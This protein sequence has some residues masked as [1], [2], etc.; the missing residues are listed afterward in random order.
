MLTDFANE[1]IHLVPGIHI[2]YSKNE[3][4]LQKFKKKNDYF[5]S[6][7]SLLLYKKRIVGTKWIDSFA[8]TWYQINRFICKVSK[9]D[10]SANGI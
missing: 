1:S 8:N 4:W 5:R 7:Y 6:Q 10:D 3:Y 2:L 9:L